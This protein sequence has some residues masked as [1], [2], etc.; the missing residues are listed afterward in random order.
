LPVYSKTGIIPKPVIWLGDSRKAVQGF[1]EAAKHQAGIEL[2]AVQLGANPTDWKPMRSIGAG[3]NEIRVHTENE[4]RVIYVAKFE[5][6]VYVLH[7]FTKKTHETSLHDVR[8]AQRRY[9]DM[10]AQRGRK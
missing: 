2:F 3:A 4:Y 1:S 9:R 7:A 6:A 10:I 8:L 5:E